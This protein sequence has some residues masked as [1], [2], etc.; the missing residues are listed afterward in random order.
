M[1]IES[2]H[3]LLKSLKKW[4]KNIFVISHV[5]GIK[6][7]VDNVIDITKKGKDSNVNCNGREASD[8]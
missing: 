5:D 2:C 8:G 4:F 3:L 6:D 7:I 1:N